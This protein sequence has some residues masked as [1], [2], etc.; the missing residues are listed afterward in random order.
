MQENT[1]QETLETQYRLVKR[2]VNTSH[3][4]QWGQLD[5]DAQTVSVFLGSQPTGDSDDVYGPFP[6]FHDPCLVSDVMTTTT[7]PSLIPQ[8]SF[9]SFS[10]K[11]LFSQCNSASTE[12]QKNMWDDEFILGVVGWSDDSL[13]GMGQGDDS[14]GEGL[15]D[16]SLDGVM[17]F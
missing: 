13:G 7:G 10:L 6:P 12:L 4:L 8:F 17:I 5:I 15:G 14:L 9:T 16:D 2:E 1:T 3:V 11:V